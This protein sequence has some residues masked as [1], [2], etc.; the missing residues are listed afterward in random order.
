MPAPAEN[1]AVLR[2]TSLQVI[3]DIGAFPLALAAGFVL[4][5]LVVLVIGLRDRHGRSAIDRSILLLAVLAGLAFLSGAIRASS[6]AAVLYEIQGRAGV[7]PGALAYDHYMIE[8]ERQL[9][10][11]IALIA[12]LGVGGLACFRKSP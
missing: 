9:F 2:S 3:R 6:Y 7:D 11:Y 12:L 4:A 8:C 1:F 5:I 10:S